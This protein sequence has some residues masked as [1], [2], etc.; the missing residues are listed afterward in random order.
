MK[1]REEMEVSEVKPHLYFATLTYITS[2]ASL[3]RR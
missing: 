3:T 1:A 2:L